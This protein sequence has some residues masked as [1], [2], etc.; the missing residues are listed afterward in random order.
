LYA[1]GVEPQTRG[2]FQPAITLQT[3]VNMPE[4]RVASMS[5]E[6]LDTYQRLLLELR[7]LLPPDEPKRIG[8]VNR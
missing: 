6:E 4:A 8:S 1:F 2:R 7:E 3:Q 5:D